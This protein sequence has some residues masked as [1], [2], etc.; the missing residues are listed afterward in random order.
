MASDW[1]T[2]TVDQIKA[3][4]DRAIA[5]GPFGSRMK[6]DLYVTQGVPVIRGNNLSAARVF[7]NDFVFV[8]HETANELLACNVFAGDLVFPHRGAIGEVG[9]VPEDGASRYM[10]STSLMKL[11]CNRELVD[12]KFVFYFFRSPAGRAALLQHASTVGTPGIGQPLASLRS[13]RV[14]VPPLAEQREIVRI[15][16]SLDDKIDLNKRMSETLEAIAQALYISWFVDFDPVR[17]KCEG[18]TTDLPNRIAELFPDSLEYSQH[19]E[20]PKGW[21]LAT[22]GDLAT[23]VGG[24]TPST[25]N[26]LYWNDGQHPWVTPKDLSALSTPVLLSTERSVTDAGLAQIGSGLLPRGTILLS[27]RAPIGYL[28]VAEISVAINQGFIGMIPHSGTSNLFLL[29]WARTAHDVIV[30]RANG[31]TFLE[32]SKTNFRPIPLVRPPQHV[33]HAFDCQARQLYERIVAN[34]RQSRTLAE[35]RDA[36]L[37]RLLSGE[38]RTKDAH[39]DVAMA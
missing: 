19:G 18:R 30:S 9:I 34:E 7:T 31:S 11:T 21:G 15:V 13:I 6:A 32:I 8:S 27:S 33:M 24:T 39:L 25:A 23:I 26:P 2:L 22:V 20:I 1:V 17:A 29:Y 3:T 37:P 5:I 14:P 12:P 16:G 35:T 36:L 10:L 28:A 4:S 38:L